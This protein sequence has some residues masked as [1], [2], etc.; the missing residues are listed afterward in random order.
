MVRREILPNGLRV[1]VRELRGAPVVA[2]N[3]WVGTGSADDPD[4]LSGLAHFIE[5][6]LF[7]P[8][9][10]PGAVHLAETVHDAG[11]Y[12]NAE[13][14]CDH[15]VYYQVVPPG[16]WRDVLAAQAEA[17]VRPAFDPDAV[18]DERSVIIEE[19]R[20]AEADPASFLWRRLMETTFQNHPC[21]R[22]VVGT[23]P[24]LA[25][26][27]PDDLR[28]HHR[29]HYVPGNMV[30]VV[31]GDVDADRVVAAAEGALGAVAGGALER[32]PV[33]EEPPTDIRARRYA[34]PWEQSSLSIAFHAPPVLHPDT[35]ALDVACGL[36]GV[37]RSSRLRKALQTSAGLVTN[38]RSGV[39]AYRDIGAATVGADVVGSDVDPAVE[40]VLAELERMRAEPAGAD[41]LD[42][43]R[44][45]LEA[46]Y[47]L[48]HET[49]GSI[50]SGLGLFETLGDYQHFEDYIDRL[51]AVTPDD[52]LRVARDYLDPRTASV[53]VYVRD[54]RGVS[55]SDRSLEVAKLAERARRAPVRVAERPAAW[56]RPAAFERP[57]MLAER[58]VGACER[59]H[60]EAGVTLVLS[61]ARALP[62]V[63]VAAAFRGG[64]AEE[65]D[66]LAGVTYLTQRLI[67][68]GTGDR[69]ADEIAD[70][71][72]GLGSAI[73]A[74]IDRDGFGFGMTVL[75]RHA[76]RG[77]GLLGDVLADP[78]FPP[79][80]LERARAEVLAEIRRL[81]DHALRRAILLML[82]M[83]FPGHPYG[84]PLRGTSESIGRMSVDDVRRWYATTLDARNL[85]VC[86]VGDFDRGAVRDAV[87]RVAC[88]LP[89]ERRSVSPGT[90][91]RGP[92][93]RVDVAH[94]RSGQSTVALGLRGPAAG[95]RDA[96][97]MRV[98]CRAGSMMG[99]RLWRA[100]RE[101]PPFAYAVGSSLIALREGGTV[102][103][104]ATAPCGHEE[105]A[106]E[107]LD[108][109]FVR[110]AAEG[111]SV[112]ELERTKRH[113][114][115]V[116]AVSM[117][118]GGARAAA[119]A[120]AE[121]TGAGFEHVDRLPDVVRSVTNDDVAAVAER[122]FG[123][124]EGRAAVILRGGPE[125]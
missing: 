120:M 87:A 103:A 108:A 82:P 2:L 3:L 101:R 69:S 12:L 89:D 80:Q 65:T 33:L 42:K 16:R 93:G 39:I 74:A 113:L 32:P 17:I 46:G 29:R 41:E 71:V 10:T 8:G 19:A 104:H 58:S 105:A 102:F 92:S 122:C 95:T 85:I 13:T 115:G 31:V 91:V 4:E 45:R 30:Q 21:R 37:G 98:I 18:E 52:V 119:Y 50:A 109:E 47:V 49:S 35:P 56:G 117:E 75:G 114:A 125:G 59:E 14:G 9:S 11:G 22:P 66:D 100:L 116:L 1:I 90:V 43:M 48:E 77:M 20:G 118:R 81:E 23:E 55:M 78:S 36:L 34:G 5:H 94:D 112:R 70:A 60:L 38:V 28:Q 61:E 72:E 63:S 57:M 123:A 7:R 83:V 110:L 25:G 62:I 106:L 76:R 111:L 40:G 107:A 124:A 54:G 86:A 121:A 53:V 67:L 6:M 79:D 68:R 96:A 44:S 24:T 84:R 64:F 97:V 88:R 27:T 15:T 73:A 51:A 99:G 26:I